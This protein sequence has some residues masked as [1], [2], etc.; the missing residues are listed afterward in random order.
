M[1]DKKDS[2][3]WDCKIKLLQN[4]FYGKEVNFTAT[5]G[6][7]SAMVREGFISRSEA[8]ERLDYLKR[9]LEGKLEQLHEFLRDT[10]LEYLVP[11][12]S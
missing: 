7:L 4:Y 6:Y 12:F 5:D 3:Q 1:P 9:N 2:W 10:N 8:L 11:H